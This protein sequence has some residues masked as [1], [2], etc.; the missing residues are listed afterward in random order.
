MEDSAEE[1]ESLWVLGRCCAEGLGVDFFE[2]REGGA[3]AQVVEQ[4]AVVGEVVVERESMRRWE[5]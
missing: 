4:T 3:L 5:W 1:K 2:L